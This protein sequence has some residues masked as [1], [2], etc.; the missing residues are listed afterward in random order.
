L[1]LFNIVFAGQTTMDVMYLWAGA[2]L[3]EG[4]T[5]AEYAHR[6]AYP[7]V[8]T[9]LLAGLFVLVT[10][11]PAGAARHS[12][13]ARGLVCLWIGQNLFLLISAIWRLLLYIDAYSLT[14][15]RIAALIWMVL[16]AIGLALL[17]WRIV[18]D[19]DNGWLLR[20]VSVAALV[21]LYACCFVP[22][23]RFIGDYNVAHCRE[24]GGRGAP[25][26]L[27]YLEHL[28]PSALPAVMR[29][30]DELDP[31]SPVADQAN[32]VFMNLSTRLDNQLAD[33]RGWSVQRQ[34]LRK[35]VESIPR[36]AQGAHKTVRPGQGDTTGRTR[37]GA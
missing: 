3:P 30:I 18:A 37:S 25:I 19:R 31:Q 2:A 9:A 26:D 6:G 36:T 11:R 10:F 22:F 7:L 14:R 1:A 24:L 12:G 13:W 4:M 27:S 34:R 32:T 8:A 17:I 15:W 35:H 20:W 21:T 16:V 5:F 29:L 23:N 33:W 28:G